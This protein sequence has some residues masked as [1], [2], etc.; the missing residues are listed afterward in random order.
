MRMML[1]C[2]IVF[3]LLGVSGCEKGTADQQVAASELY[4]L[5]GDFRLWDLQQDQGIDNDAIRMHVADSIVQH[6]LV[7]RVAKYEIANLGGTPL[8]ALCRATTDEARQIIQK[9]G[10]E[11]LSPVALSYI[12]EVEPAVL[13]EI[14]QS[15]MTMLDG[16][17]FL[18]PQNFR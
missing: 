3:A 8:G 1:S 12:D 5:S 18:T 17:C 16:G 2:L 15:Q 11:S 14:R 10:N 13:D 6:L 4:S 7:L 9:Y